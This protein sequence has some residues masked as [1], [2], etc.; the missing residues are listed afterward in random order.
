[1]T[2]PA[3]RPLTPPWRGGRT[4]HPNPCTEVV[5]YRIW[6]LLSAALLV[7]VLAG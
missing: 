5:V 6:L 2:G 3:A 1:M 7:A 4:T